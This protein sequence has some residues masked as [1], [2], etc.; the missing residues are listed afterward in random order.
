M[1]P[2][3]PGTFRTIGATLIALCLSWI[4][5]GS[6]SA[7]VV[8]GRVLHSTRPEAVE[9]LEIL[10]LGI[11]GDPNSDTIERRTRSDSDGHFRFD[12]LPAPAAYLLRAIFA[13]VV[14]PGGTAIFRPG[15]PESAD[16]VVIHVFDRS[17]DASALSINSMQ[18]VFEREAGVYRV[19]VNVSI[20]NSSAMMVQIDPNDPPAIR[21]PLPA[22]YSEL[23]LPF[24]KLPKG[25]TIAG[26]V[27]EVRGPVMPGEEGLRVNFAFDLGD[28]S[29]LLETELRFPDRV[30]SLRLYVRDFGIEVTA[31][32]LHPAQPARQDDVFYLGFVGFDLPPGQ[33]SRVRIEPLASDQAPA[34]GLIAGLVALLAGGLLFL[35]GQPI[36]EAG[37][38]GKVVRLPDDDEQRHSDAL[39]AALRDLEH[40]FET[41]KL[42]EEDRDRLR[43]ELRHEAAR[44][45]ARERGVTRSGSNPGKTSA[46]TLRV[47]SCGR[48]AR[49]DDRFCGGCG[50][51]L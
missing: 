28:D 2:A 14:F 21:L 20:A 46:D 16:P 5:A 32:G 49:P 38:D 41:A 18:W 39:R 42:S 6:V 35:V 22:G 24:G 12:D 34:D 33:V 10:A 43:E 30:D 1:I 45:L 51:E 47:C 7:A 26:E 25:V 40:D 27:V 29:A 23:K 36:A 37:G 48:E 31:D 4:G 3:T 13:G 8:E 17:E 15:E 19:D 44:A 9:N 11:S 50:T